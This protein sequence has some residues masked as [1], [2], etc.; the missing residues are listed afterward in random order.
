[1]SNYSNALKSSIFSGNSSMEK[2]S[3]P[4][5]DEIIKINVD[6]IQ[7]EVIEIKT[8]YT[9]TPGQLSKCFI[10]QTNLAK[11][12]TLLTLKLFLI[13]VKIKAS[14]NK[15]E[16]SDEIYIINKTWYEQYKRYSRY[17]TIKRAIKAFS[18]YA[19]RPI[20]YTPYENINPGIINNKDLYIKNKINSN[21]GRNLLVSKNNNAYDTRFKVCL[22]QRDRFN[23]LKNYFK[24]DMEIKLNKERSFNNNKNYE[25]YCVHL[26]AVF[27]PTKEIFKE[28]SNEN[29]EEFYKKYN[30]IYDLYFRQ[31][32]RADEIINELKIIIKER[33][34]LLSKIGVKFVTEGNEDEIMNHFNFLKYYIPYES[35]TKTK[36]EILDFIL[37]KSSIEK[38]KNNLKISSED[39]P[40]HKS[41]SFY[42]NISQ[43]FHLKFEKV[44]KPNNIDEVK[45]GLIII[46]YI[47]CDKSNEEIKFSIFEEEKNPPKKED[48]TQYHS[49]RYN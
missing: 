3:N 17:S 5:N 40:I 16:G 41:P 31:N 29:Y 36:Q 1:M 7:N 28:I 15:V 24:C 25:D 43:L 34:E 44:Q 6:N 4:R 2:E 47:P 18:I 26:N 10:P 33:P 8:G 35:N 13:N 9:Y 27:I 19:S 14:Q 45:N 48:N 46:E 32:S 37:S 22:I 38:I 30:I 20:S 23:L 39:I 11:E 12:I 21:D 42:K 49:H